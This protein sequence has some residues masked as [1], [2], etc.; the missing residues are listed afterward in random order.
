MAETVDARDVAG[1]LGGKAG[2]GRA[3]RNFGDLASAV[4]EG[5]PSAAMRAL[6]LRSG[7]TAKE[8][9][10]SVRIPERTLMRIQKRPRLPADESDKIYRFAYV[11]AFAAKVFGDREKANDWLRRPNRGL[12]GVVPLQLIATEPGLRQVER[13]LGRIEYGEIS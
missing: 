9:S 13:E 11:L 3:V 6:V 8:I 12:G 7:A 5:L 2:V 1:L 10:Q 4:E